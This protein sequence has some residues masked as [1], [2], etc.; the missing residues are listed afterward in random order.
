VREVKMPGITALLHT[1]NDELRIGRALETLR[2]C[3]EI[4]IIDHGSHDRT[5]R[6]AREYGVVFRRANA[7]AKES[8][9]FA[10]FEWVLCLRPSES[11]SEALEASLYEWK[12]RVNADLARVEGVRLAIREEQDGNWTES[13]PELRL[14]RR[15][16]A[17]WASGLPSGQPG[18]MQLEGDLLRF[19]NP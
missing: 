19:R 8:A 10:K 9:G 1:C 4:V 5:L 2:P 18:S 13:A 11:V 15:E 17:S 7:P 16:W 6:L 14:V 12:L 3:D